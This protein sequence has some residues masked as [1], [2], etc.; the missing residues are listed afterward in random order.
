MPSSL[1]IGA[2]FRILG[3]VNVLVE[4]TVEA[5]TECQCFNRNRVRVELI[6]VAEVD[7][8]MCD[9][10]SISNAYKSALFTYVLISDH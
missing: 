8:R 6:R 3:V 1:A 2:G 7:E 9:C 10:C 4:G 5:G